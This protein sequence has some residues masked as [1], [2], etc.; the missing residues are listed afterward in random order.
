MVVLM[1]ILCNVSEFRLLF[2]LLR[3]DSKKI[4]FYRVELENVSDQLVSELGFG[5]VDFALVVFSAHTALRTGYLVLLRR[6]AD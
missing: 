5:V 2:W 4:R 6:A 3:N 1:K